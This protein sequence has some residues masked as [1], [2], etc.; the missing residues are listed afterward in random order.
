MHLNH[1]LSKHPRLKFSTIKS[2]PAP[3]PPSPISASTMIWQ[4]SISLRAL[5]VTNAIIGVSGAYVDSIGMVVLTGK[6]K[7]EGMLDENQSF[8]PKLS[9]RQLPARTIVSPS[10]EDLAPF[11]SR[12][13][14]AN[15]M[16]TD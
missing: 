13:E 9:S 12:D 6:V 5:G 4:W 1:S 11:L 16:V 7:R 8:A 10:L 14:L 2:R 15:N 3:S